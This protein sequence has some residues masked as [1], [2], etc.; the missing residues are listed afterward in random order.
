MHLQVNR[1]HQNSQKKVNVKVRVTNPLRKEYE[2]YILRDITKEAVSTPTELRKEL[3]KQLGAELVSPTLDFSVGYVKGNSKVTIHSPGDIDDVWN[4]LTSSKGEAVTLWC[5]RAVK[6]DE[7]SS[8]NE[9]EQ[10]DYAVRPKSKK[11]KTLSALEKKN[12]RVESLVEK[13]RKKHNGK[14]TT[15]QLR[16]WAEVVHGGSWK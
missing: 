9:S 16:L 6:R 2:T 11:K 4:M 10:E 15:L 12:E 3:Y 8:E 5:D 1:R 13:L 14:F 7:E